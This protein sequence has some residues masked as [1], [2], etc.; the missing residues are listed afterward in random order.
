MA[1]TGFRGG[2][3]GFLAQCGALNA[4]IMNVGL[5]FGRTKPEES[6]QCASEITKLLCERFQDEMGHIRCDVLRDGYHCGNRE[7]PKN[8]M[9]YFA[10][11][12]LAA[13]V[14]LTAHRDCQECGGFEGAIRRLQ[15]SQDATR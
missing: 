15:A 5:L 4:G 12:K 14:L 8:N 2:G 9:V 1:S 11:A 3:G 10:G 7:D 13:E 6:N